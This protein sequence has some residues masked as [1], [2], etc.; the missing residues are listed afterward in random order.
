MLVKVFRFRHNQEVE[1]DTE[2]FDTSEGSVKWVNDCGLNGGYIPMPYYVL[3]CYMSYNMA[4]KY[5]LASGEHSSIAKSAKVFLHY[6]A[7]KE[8]KY[9]EGYEYLCGIAGRKPIRY[10]G[11]PSGQPPCTKKILEELGTEKHLRADIRKCLMDLG[12]DE[13]TIRGAFKRLEKTGRIFFSSSNH[14][15]KNCEVWAAT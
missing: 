1:I 7:N 12:Y 3:Q 13:N 9:K 4:V 11:V 10:T 14:S 5:G 6:K 2:F 8:P 15:L